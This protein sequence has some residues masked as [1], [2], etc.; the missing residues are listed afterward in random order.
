L[1]GFPTR[2][3]GVVRLSGCPNL[4]PLECRYALQ[5]RVS[6]FDISDNKPLADILNNYNL[7]AGPEKVITGMRLLRNI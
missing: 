7:S 3:A 1:R 2:V 6:H 5:S 4:Q